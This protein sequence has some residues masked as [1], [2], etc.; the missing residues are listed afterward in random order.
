MIKFLIEHF[1]SRFM[2]IYMY[3]GHPEG[4]S[5]SDFIIYQYPWCWD[6][7]QI[8]VQLQ[9]LMNGPHLRYPC[10]VTAMIDIGG[11]WIGKVIGVDSSHRNQ[12]VSTPEVL[13]KD[14]PRIKFDTFPLQKSYRFCSDFPISCYIWVTALSPLRI[15]FVP[16]ADLYRT[17]RRPS[18]ASHPNASRLR[19]SSSLRLPASSWSVPKNCK[20]GH[21]GE[22]IPNPP[23]WVYKAI[24]ISACPFCH[25]FSKPETWWCRVQW[26]H[27]GK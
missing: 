1:C 2:T 8:A 5:N 15:P 13:L 4:L 22:L 14:I 23:H 16:Q 24:P 6:I 25:S 9:V 11:H 17:Y 12:V 7:R 10:H 19:V 26:L 27:A 21:G 3:N 18:I 20:E